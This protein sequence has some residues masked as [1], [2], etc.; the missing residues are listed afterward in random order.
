MKHLVA[1]IKIYLKIWM[2]SLRA[3]FIQRT[4]NR[5]NFVIICFAV[6]IQ[7]ALNLTFINIIFRFIEK[8]SGWS[9]YQALMIVSS[10]MIIEGLMW[11][12]CAYLVGIYQN[13]YTGKLDNL[14]VKP[15]D[16]QFLVSIWRGDPEDWVRVLVAFGTFIYAF[17]HIDMA[18]QNIFLNFIFYSI[19]LACAFIITYSLSLAIKSILFW[20]IEINSLWQI[21]E[22]ITRMSQYPTDI[23]YHKLI[24]IFFSTMI[25][26]AFL[27]TVPAKVLLYGPSPAHV[28]SGVGLALIFFYL[29]RK[30]WLFALRHYSSA[31]N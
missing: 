8:L 30:F 10:Y 18:G 13:I 7:M 22:N 23:F 4:A 19:L 25:P 16:A 1:N 29:S 31:S 21:T 3:S 26:L 12:T 5:K 11:C 15:K 17:R 9:F 28:L 24:R 6:F 2:I 27:A 20:S 14:L